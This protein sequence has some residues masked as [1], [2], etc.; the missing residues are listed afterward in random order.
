MIRSFADNE[1]RKL[2]ERGESAKLSPELLRM[3]LRKLEYIDNAVSPNDLRLPPDN[4]LHKLKGQ[5]DGQFSISVNDQW[6]VCFR[7]ESEN[8]YDVEICD[9]H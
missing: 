1:T 3:A 7:F 5:R 9:Y 4:R 6:R 2:F 8:A